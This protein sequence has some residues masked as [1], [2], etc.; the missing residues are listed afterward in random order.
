MYFCLLGVNHFVFSGCPLL[1]TCF[2]F[3]RYLN[4]RITS[5]QT[6][7]KK[8]YLCSKHPPLSFPFLFCLKSIWPPPKK[9]CQERVLKMSCNNYNRL[10]QFISKNLLLKKNSQKKDHSNEKTMCNG[11]NPCSASLHL[12]EP[13]R[14]QSSEVRAL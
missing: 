4:L 12:F 7:R 10:A 14:L 3:R 5:K 2:F 9:N 1:I 8:R 11:K 13:K 6:T